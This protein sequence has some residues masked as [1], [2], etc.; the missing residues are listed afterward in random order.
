MRDIIRK[1]L[2]EESVGKNLIN[3]YGIDIPTNKKIYVDKVLKRWETD[4]LYPKEF[5]DV[6]GIDMDMAIY[7]RQKIAEQLSNVPIDKKISVYDKDFPDDISIGNYDISFEIIKMDD[8]FPYHLLD[9]TKYGKENQRDFILSEEILV[10]AKLSRV[11]SV[12]I[13][14][15]QDDGEHELIEMP[16]MEAIHDE[17]FGWEV[18]NEIKD[19]IWAYIFSFSPL[20]TKLRTG[21]DITLF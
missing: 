20:A 15:R 18:E 21:C 1:I 12:H 17:D 13:N 16:I 7:I 19:I 5:I 10:D 6:Y 3:H 14:I 4:T 8:L 11:G 2:K 9:V